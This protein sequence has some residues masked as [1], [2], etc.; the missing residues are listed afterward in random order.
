MV[1]VQYDYSKGQLPALT[2]VI[3][4]SGAKLFVCAVGVPPK[5]MV[6]K[7]HTAG[8]VVMKYDP[9]TRCIPSAAHVDRSWST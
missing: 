6:E 9:F 1:W 2:D 4:K 7:L 8:I 5:E 3:I